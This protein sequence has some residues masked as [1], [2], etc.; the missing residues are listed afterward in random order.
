MAT[1]LGTTENKQLLWGLLM[2]EGI[3]DTIPRNVTL[4]EVQR[5]FEATLYNLS[6]TANP[7]ASL[8]E[9]N[10]LAIETLANIIPEIKSDS[11]QSGM[12]I[13][14]EDIRNQKRSEIDA[15]LREKEAESRAYLD[16][17]VPQAIDFSD[18][19]VVIKS[20][21]RSRESKQVSEIVDMTSS[22]SEISSL[23][24]AAPM[25][26][27]KPNFKNVDDVEAPPISRED[28][29]D[30]PIGDEMDKLIAERIATRERDLTEITNRII[31]KDIAAKHEI[32]IMRNKV[33][34]P[35]EGHAGGS[36]A[37]GVKVRFSDKVITREVEEVTESREDNVT[38][39]LN[40]IYSQLKRKPQVNNVNTAT[41]QEDPSTKIKRLEDT[42]NEMKMQIDQL[43][44]RQN[45][46]F[47]RFGGGV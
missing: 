24:N 3:F 9:L 39:E 31:P 12:I 37:G 26:L 44:R 41:I 46:M 6:K 5:V 28:I 1:S 10:R 27:H 13:T 29:I 45:E 38:A 34:M 47:E 19:G 18:K 25:T 15:K 2:E 40:H 16:R 36:A 35:Y 20:A 30:S 14:A 8:I 7:T 32:M 17:P 4:P 22:L 23:L 21:L 11:R 33:Q 43:L 42:V